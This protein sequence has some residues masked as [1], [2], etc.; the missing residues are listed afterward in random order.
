MV[1]QNLSIAERYMRGRHGFCL[2]W[3]RNLRVGTVAAR[4][5]VCGGDEAVLTRLL[6]LLLPRLRTGEGCQ[7]GRAMRHLVC[8][9]FAVTP[10]H[11][12]AIRV[13][14]C[15][16]IERETPTPPIPG[17]VRVGM[18]EP[19]Q[20]SSATSRPRPPPAASPQHKPLAS[21]SQT[22]CLRKLQQARVVVPQ[23]LSPAAQSFTEKAVSR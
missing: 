21:P 3:Y 4:D 22:S 2:D 10:R 8:R 14:P 20:H 5:G 6:L 9:C 15:C 16:C 7:Q 18:T 19:Q 23:S 13:S 11:R 12:P 1:A 17:A